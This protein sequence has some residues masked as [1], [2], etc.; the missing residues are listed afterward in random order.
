MDDGILNTEREQNFGIVRNVTSP[1]GKYVPK[2]SYVAYGVMARQLSVAKFEQKETIQDSIS[3][4]LFSDHNEDIRVM[5]SSKPTLIT[6]KTS[7]PIIVTDMMGVAQTY[8][9]D[10]NNTIYLSL[11]EQPIYVR[12]ELTEVTAGSQFTLSDGEA[13]IGEPVIM[14]LIVNNTAPAAKPI[15]AV[16][17]IGELNYSVKTAAGVREEIIITLPP[18]QEA[19]IWPVAAELMMNG[20]VIGRLDA[21]MHIKRP[22]TLQAKHQWDEMRNAEFLSVTINNQ[23]AVPQVVDSL[24]WNIGGT[25]GVEQLQNTIEG[26]SSLE[27][28]L[29]LSQLADSQTYNFELKLYAQQSLFLSHTDKI[30]I[31]K[32]ASITAIPKQTVPINDTLDELANLP[33]IDIVKDGNNRLSPYYGDD[34][35]SGQAWLSWDKQNLYFSARIQDNIFSQTAVG[36]QMWQ[37]DSIQF[38]LAAGYP[39]ERQERF[40]YGIALTPEGPQIYSWYAHGK[41]PGFQNGQLFVKRDEETQQTIYKLALP[42]DDISPINPADGLF[43]FSFLVN[44]NDGQG[45][46]GYI[47]WGSGIGTAKNPAL[48]KP[49]RLVGSENEPLVDNEAPT[50]LEGSLLTALDITKTSVKLQW[51]QAQDNRSVT[52][53]KIYLNDLLYE[54]RNVGD[55]CQS[56]AMDDRCELKIEGLLPGNS[57]RVAVTALDAAENESIELNTHIKTLS[58]PAITTPDSTLSSNAE[59]QQLLLE[60]LS[61]SSDSNILDLSPDFSSNTLFYTTETEAEHVKLIVTTKN[62]LAKV[63][64]AAEGHAKIVST[65]EKNSNNQKTKEV[66]QL[67][68]DKDHAYLKL[69]EGNNKYN[70]K[71]QADNGVE[72]NYTLTIYRKSAKTDDDQEINNNEHLFSDLSGHWAEKAIRK[73]AATGIVS[74]Y[75]DGSFQPDKAITRSEFTVLLINTLNEKKKHAPT[76]ANIEA[77]GKT[78]MAPAISFTD[79]TQIEAWASTAI[80]QAVQAGIVTG[81][82][83]GSFRPQA[84]ITRMEMAVMLARAAQLPLQESTEKT[85]YVDDAQI[86]NWARPAVLAVQQALL[87]QGKNGNKFAPLAKASRAESVVTL[88]RMIELPN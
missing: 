13:V 50:W 75:S 33:A 76:T 38:A 55:I 4:Y 48:F 46:K 17:R 69:E 31:P 14:K 39:G 83:D 86:A 60:I 44:D 72:K 18:Q 27:I 19:G 70:I 8:A 1:Y 23:S 51:P 64:L 28:L 20:E 67:L 34:D 30:V 45:R 66:S 7:T 29:P 85:N 61:D 63:T 32:Q 22:F 52:D 6:L 11:S 88:L 73:G 12:G 43:S 53:Y 84:T 78:E 79:Q 10:Q 59:L 87:M 82:A 54:K 36:D 65:D 62:K 80:A 74:G 35:L 15:D 68:L 77:S 42:W 58:I 24:V 3:S 47:E 41:N 21:Q 2:P 81:Y 71:V 40:E 5:W 56:T 9:P 25:N 26:H 57:Y 16:L 37:G 49:I